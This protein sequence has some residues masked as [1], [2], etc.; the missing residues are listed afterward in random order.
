MGVYMNYP[1]LKGDATETGFQN[2]ITVQSVEFNTDRNITTSAGSTKGRE[3][4]QPT[5]SEVT[6]TKQLDASS[7]ALFR[8]AVTL[9]HG[10]TVNIAFTKTNAKGTPFLQYD[11]SDVMISGYKFEGDGDRPME[12]VRLSCA[13]FQMTVTA[14]DSANKSLASVTTGYDLALNQAI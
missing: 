3:A 8:A 11:L 13:Q 2:W 6:L 4:G 10:K 9:S 1:G 5:V 14:T 12:T 7:A